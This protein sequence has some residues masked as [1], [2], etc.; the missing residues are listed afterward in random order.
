MARKVLVHPPSSGGFSVVSIDFKVKSLLVQWVKRLSVSPNGWVYLLKYWLLDRFDATPV[1]VFSNPHGFLASRLPP[2]YSSML[3][4]WIAFGG[5]SSPAGLVLGFGAPGGPLVV[6]SITC[7]I[8]YN[9]LL[10]LN[11]AR[12]HCI[13]KICPLLWCA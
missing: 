3:E 5:S 13:Q 7:K 8:C 6:S 4:S 10:V 12:P 2:F 9:L 11:P 1:D